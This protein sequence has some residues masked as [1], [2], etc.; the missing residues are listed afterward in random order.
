MESSSSQDSGVLAILR[1]F[2]DRANIILAKGDVKI[3]QL[4]MWNGGL[5]S[6]IKKIHGPE[7]EAIKALFPK[8]IPNNINPSKELEKRRLLV[9]RYVAAVERA[10]ITAFVDRSIGSHIFIGHGRSPMWR[11]LKDFLNDRLGFPWDEFNR[12]AV[13]GITTFERI[14]TMLDSASFAF[15]IMTAEDQ[16]SDATTHARQNVVHEVGLFQGKLGPRKAIILIEEGCNEFSNI[17]GLSQIRFPKGQISAVFE[18]IRRVL[19]REGV[20]RT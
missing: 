16:H 6:Q 2:I 18:E 9:E 5:I 1:R 15:L 14:E 4:R 8:L 11:E 12:E 13:A 3:G 19:E 7:H 10:G 17:V 20:I